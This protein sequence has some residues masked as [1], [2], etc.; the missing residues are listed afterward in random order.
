M[1]VQDAKLVFIDVETTGLSPAMGDRIIEV[2]VVA[3][4]PGERPR[5]ASQLVNPDRA[6]PLESRRVHGIG[7][8]DVSEAPAFSAVARTLGE[9]IAGSWL[10]GHNVR[11]DVGFLAM[12][13]ALAGYQVDPAGCLDTCQLAA[14]AFELPDYRL[15]TLTAALGIQ[16]KAKHRAL[17][18][19]LATQAVFDFTV[20]EIGDASDLTIADLRA[21]HR[22]EPTWPAHPRTLLPGPLYDALT[23]GQLISIGYVNGEGRASQRM[24]RPF[25]CFPVGRHVYVRAHCTEAAEMRTFRLDRIVEVADPAAA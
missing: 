19:A 11:F 25:S 20:K 5:Q 17:D 24:I 12:E 16:R 10:I 15:D 3:C 2:G 23:S 1:R 6:I 18:D 13:M 21:L 4:A 22:Y 7:D 14:A 9:L 8:E